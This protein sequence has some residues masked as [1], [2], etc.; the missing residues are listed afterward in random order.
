M[1]PLPGHCPG[2]AFA[3]VSSAGLERFDLAEIGLR[4]F[5]R[6]QGDNRS[7]VANPSSY[8]PRSEAATP[9]PG[10]AGAG[11]PVLCQAP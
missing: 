6:V 5:D 9:M 10:T 3:T 7:V 1:G 8:H 4:V 2:A 11:Q